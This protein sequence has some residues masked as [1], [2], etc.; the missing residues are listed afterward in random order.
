[1]YSLCITVFHGSSDKTNQI[2]LHKPGDFCRRVSRL[3]ILPV[4][5][6]EHSYVTVMMVLSHVW[7]SQTSTGRADVQGCRLNCS[8]VLEEGAKT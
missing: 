5:L 4:K 1:M 6:T 7:H 8:F 3:M 2:L